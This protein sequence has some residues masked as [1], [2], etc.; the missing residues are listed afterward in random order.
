MKVAGRADFS[1]KIKPEDEAETA[2]GMG[3]TFVA[4][5]IAKQC[6]QGTKSG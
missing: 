5:G 3:I 4:R 2:T 1:Q 6:F